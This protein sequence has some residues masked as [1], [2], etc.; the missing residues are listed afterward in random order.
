MLFALEVPMKIRFRMR[1]LSLG[2]LASLTLFLLG[3][4]VTV[5]AQDGALETRPFVEKFLESGKLKEGVAEL[6]ARLDSRP[7]DDQARFGLGVLQ[8]MQAVEHLGQSIYRYGVNSDTVRS[9]PFLRLRVPENP[10]PQTIDYAAARVILV[11]METCLDQAEET[12]ANINDSEVKLPLHLFA[13]HIDFDQDGEV[14]EEE[15]VAR[16]VT[17]FVGQPS[18]DSKPE[19]IVIV[20][21]QADVYWLRGYCCLLRSMINVV[22]AYDEEAL[23]DVIAHRVFNKTELKYEFLREEIEEAKQKA[24]EGKRPRGFFNFERKSIL[25]LLGAIHNLNFPLKDIDRMQRA[26]GLLKQ[27]IGH[28]RAMWESA[29]GESDND[30]EWIPNSKQKCPIVRADITPKMLESWDLFLDESEAVL[31]GRKLI[32]FWRGTD[33]NRG[34]NLHKVFNEPR[35]MDIVLWIHGSAA[36]PYLEEGELTEPDTWRNIRRS[37]GGNFFFF[38]SWFN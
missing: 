37:F 6:S 4:S 25:D 2:V 38:A 12:L 15:N 18:G 27:T 1:S 36:V 26:H 21:D 7:N 14:V 22:L 28:S 29:K 33:K 8:F 13:F 23:W 35:D 19:N 34:I 16:L 31:D 9:T 11:Q 5:A 10:D 24:G 17:Q 30:R 3:L 20:F 32:P